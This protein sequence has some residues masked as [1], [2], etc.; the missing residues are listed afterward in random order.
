MKKVDFSPVNSQDA[1]GRAQYA[2]DEAKNAR[3]A[4]NIINGLKELLKR[5][6]GIFSNSPVSISTI[7]FYLA[8]LMEIF[9]SFPMYIDL[10]TDLIGQPN[11]YKA[12][13]GA[14]LIVAWGAGVSHFI[15]KK[16]SPA[17]VEYA[18]ANRV[19]SSGGDKPRIAVEEE[20]SRNTRR[21]FRFGLFLG[22]LLMVVVIAISWQRVFLRG[23]ITGNYSII[24]KLLPVIC[25]FIEI[26]SGIYLGYLYNRTRKVFLVYWWRYILK[27]NTVT[28]T[29]ETKM[30]YGLYQHAAELN[31]PVHYTKE[32]AD[33]IYRY[34]KRGHDSENYIDPIPEQKS[35]KVIIE[36]GGNAVPGV[37]LSGILAN[38]DNCNSIWTNDAGEGLLT[39][40]GEER[41][42]K[43][44]YVDGKIFDGPYRENSTV[45]LNL[46]P[47]RR[48]Q[49]V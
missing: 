42:V 36:N 45:R 6:S 5:W 21:E 16:M 22:A 26:I 18:I 48:I 20:V 12:L 24:H 29:Y 33:V 31:E 14:L 4:R 27:R 3:K 32:M 9:F 11:N 40:E 37:H 41:I 49:A 43:A 1:I 38:N 44:I 35:L 25:V 8:C 7:I 15:G 28:C 39:W 19:E 47:V 17:L 34:E 10:M 30:A 46:K 2:N 23:A 13:I